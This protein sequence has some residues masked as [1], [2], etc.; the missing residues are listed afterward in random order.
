M[1]RF[2]SWP[3]VWRQSITPMV[4]VPKGRWR[5]IRCVIQGF[6]HDKWIDKCRK[7][8]CVSSPKLFEKV[9]LPLL[10]LKFRLSMQ[11]SELSLFLNLFTNGIGC[12][13]RYGPKTLAGAGN[14]YTKEGSGRLES[15]F[16]FGLAITM[17]ADMLSEDNCLFF[18]VFSLRILPLSDRSEGGRYHWN[19]RRDGFFD[20][21]FFGE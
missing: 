8:H 14:W 5:R 4:F 10:L 17:F 3:K 2:V 13:C 6:Q 20:G 12:E 21:G 9:S 16:F 11:N 19:W 7:C 18:F 1:Q 15:D